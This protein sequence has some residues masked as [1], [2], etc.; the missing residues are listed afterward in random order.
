MTTEP[1]LDWDDEEAPTD[2]GTD[3][4]PAR[5]LVADDDEALRFVIV[6]RLLD[7]GYEVFEAE[8]GADIL[9]KL[10]VMRQDDFPS[11]GFDL[12]VLDHRMPGL[13]GL[14][15]LRTLRASRC[16]IPAI[17]MTAFPDATLQAEARSL[18]VPLLSKPFSLA[19]LSDVAVATLLA[20]ARATATGATP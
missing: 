5:V 8:S 20:R 10:D 18:E 3:A 2:V 14:D 13:T 6:S 15:V 9:T 1:N 7:D 12:L 11:E 16:E 17:L 19:T 4:G